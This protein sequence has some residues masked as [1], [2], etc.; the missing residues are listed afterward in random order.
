MTSNQHGES[1]PG[2]TGPDAPG[3]RT[4]EGSETVVE[5]MHKDQQRNANTEK[6]SAEELP[7]P[8]RDSTT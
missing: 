5:Q 3:Q 2:L 7:Q 6:N 4:G 8:A 1:G